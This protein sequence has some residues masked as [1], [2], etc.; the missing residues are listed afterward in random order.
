MKH[1]VIEITYTAPL[2]KID[3]TLPEH[4]AFLQTGYDKGWLLMSG[5]QNPRTGGIVIAR[6]P[7]LDDLQALFSHDPYQLKG[8]AS[9]RFIEFNPVKKAPLMDVWVN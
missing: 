6:A 9:Y 7:S 3:E 8:Q 5:P 4:R 2:D 1:F